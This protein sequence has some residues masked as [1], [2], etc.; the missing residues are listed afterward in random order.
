MAG[1]GVDTL[2]N[3][4][5]TKARMATGLEMA[6][7]G[8]QR[9]HQGSEG[10]VP[11]LIFLNTM[12]VGMAL[13][14]FLSAA[15]LALFFVTAHADTKNNSGFL[16]DYS[17][18]KEAGS[19]RHRYLAYQAPDNPASTSVALYIKPMFAYPVGAAFPEVDPDVVRQSLNYANQVL[20][21]KLAS[22]MTL[23]DD[24]E[25][26]TVK[27]EVALTDVS[28]QAEGKT[29]L[30]LVPLRLI[31]NLAK[32]ASSGKAMEAVARMEF[33]LMDSKTQKIRYESVHS[34]T[35]KSLGRA[36]KSG[37]PLDFSAL[38]PAID[39]WASNIVE[40]ITSQL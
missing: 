27:V 33:R 12:K 32:T 40:E 26:S 18:L 11:Q 9:K 38:K 25:Q 5:Q 28:A 15:V 17:R 23:V 31:T 30:D 36:E 21:H 2:A 24:P 22:K 20:R 3:E 7:T 10:E 16:E 19:L 39:A 13:V 35:G 1:S 34:Q 8:V 6:S 37:A 14:K 4:K 29:V